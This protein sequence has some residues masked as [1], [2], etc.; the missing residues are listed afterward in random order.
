MTLSSLSIYV[1][2]VDPHQGNKDVMPFSLPTTKS[3]VEFIG[4]GIY[5]CKQNM[6]DSASAQNTIV[7]FYREYFRY[8]YFYFTTQK[9]WNKYLLG[10]EG[11]SVNI[12]TQLEQGI[13]IMIG[14]MLND[15]Q[16]IKL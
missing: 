13:N 12:P 10:N 8:R 2:F 15:T 3:C 4:V 14:V 1:V 5:K 11:V 7:A 16:W 9:Q 6:K